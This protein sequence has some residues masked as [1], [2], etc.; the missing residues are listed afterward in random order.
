MS[1][2]HAVS[3]VR[4]GPIRKHPNADALEITDVDGRPVIL[5]SG[6][7]T[8]GDLAI[9]VPI[10][11]LVPV[12]DPRF[13]FLASSHKTDSEGRARIRAARLRGVFSMGLLVPVTMPGEQLPLVPFAEGD[14][15][16]AALGI[17]TWEPGDAFGIAPDAEKD[18]GFLPSYDIESAR[19]W[20]PLCLT[21]GEEVHLT[22]KIHGANGRFAYHRDRLWVASRNRFLRE[23]SEGVAADPW[24]TVARTLDLARRLAEVPGIALYGEVYGQVQDL[25]YGVNGSALVVFDALDIETRRWLDVDELRSLCQTLELPMVPTLYRGPWMAGLGALAE[26]GSSVPGAANVREGW[27]VRPVKERVHEMLGRVIL[28]RHG[29]GYLTRKGG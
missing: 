26:G 11:A 24:W 19:K 5:R 2:E 10:D 1:T 3:V 23:P 4:V 12:A 13:S 29:E 15:V 22:E 16:S 27:V 20:G 14:E 18:P 17:G 28:K 9:Y 6:S 8:T 25:K 7:F 21:E